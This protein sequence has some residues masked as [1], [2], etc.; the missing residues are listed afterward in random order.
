[1]KLPHRRLMYFWTIALT[2]GFAIA[3]ASTTQAAEIKLM[4]SGGMRVAL[5]ALIPAFERATN[6]KVTATYGAPGTIR[7]GILAGAPWTYS[8]SRDPGSTTW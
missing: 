6:H 5:I 1:M 7:G 8:C 3:L 2:I 4:S